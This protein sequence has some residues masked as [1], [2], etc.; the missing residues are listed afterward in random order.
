MNLQTADRIIITIIR[1]ESTPILNY[2][3]IIYYNRLNFNKRINKKFTKLIFNICYIC[4]RKQIIFEFC[5]FCVA[6]R[7]TAHYGSVPC[8]IIQSGAKFA[9][10]S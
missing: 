3:L 2:I 4:I 1:R 8:V 7:K 10:F 5:P 6:R 9:N